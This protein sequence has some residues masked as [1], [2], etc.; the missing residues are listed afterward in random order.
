MTK[1][2]QPITIRQLQIGEEIKRQIALHINSIMN[3][4]I[5][6]DFL[7]LMKAEISKDLRYCK[8]FY[9]CKVKNKANYQEQLDK[10]VPEITNFLYKQMHLRIRPEIRFVFDDTM[11]I[12]EEI[13]EV[14]KRN[15][16]FV[17]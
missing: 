6:G 4:S 7:T 12:I 2:K 11:K 13:E 14:I 3:T 8:V 5:N 17:E 10:I 15:K 9:R 1:K 16:E